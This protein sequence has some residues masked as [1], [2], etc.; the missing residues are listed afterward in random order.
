MRRG[1]ILESSISV[2]GVDY[3]A[4]AHVRIQ[5]SNTRR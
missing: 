1:D 4:V 5:T 3:S 2:I